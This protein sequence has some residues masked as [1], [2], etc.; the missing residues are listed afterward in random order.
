MTL[1]AAWFHDLGP[2][3]IHFSG[4]FGVR[5]YGLSYVA[6]FLIAW[7]VLGQLARPGR[8]LFPPEAAAD[9]M[10]GVILGTI[11]GGRLGYVVIYRPELLWE[12]SSNFPF[13]GLLD[14]MHGGMASHGAM[15][16]IILGCLLT[17]RRLKVPPLHIMDCICLVAPFGI[18]LGRLANFVNGELLGRIV[19]HP[20]DAAAGA[21]VPWWGVRYPQE[22]LER[23]TEAELTPEQHRGL[24]TL[25][26]DHAA[27][28]DQSI[29]DAA[30]TVISKIHAGDHALAKALEPFIS[31]R[32]PSQIYQALAE[33]LILGLALWIVWKR[34]R[35]P[36]VVLAWFFIVYGIGRVATEFWRLPDAHLQ[37][38]RFLSLSRGQW[39]SVLMVAAGLAL[40]AWLRRSKAAPV[41]GWGGDDPQET[42]PADATLSA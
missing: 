23:A 7:W 14:V 3:A 39:L 33:G 19:V 41:G 1:L 26:S 11:L 10:F 12:F 8:L 6:G 31:I 21:P 25:L 4:S 9:A 15:V 18:A 42:R 38:Q 29:S 30:A 37:T 17:A 36:G 16:G 35:K 5:W 28:T 40:L 2:F 13:W 22:L 27:P 34:P 32:H 24:Q 20:A